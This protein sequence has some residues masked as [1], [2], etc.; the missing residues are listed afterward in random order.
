MSDF[1]VFN[2][3][4]P[5]IAAANAIASL[6][7][8]YMKTSDFQIPGNASGLIDSKYIPSVLTKTIPPIIC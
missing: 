4:V 5:S 3:G 8:G 2:I 6:S 7:M 1:K